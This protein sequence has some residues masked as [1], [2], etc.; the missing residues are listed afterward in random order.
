MKKLNRIKKLLLLSSTLFL[1]LVSFFKQTIVCAQL[2]CP[3][4]KSEISLINS[5]FEDKQ[6]VNARQYII[7]DQKNVPGWSTSARDSKIEIWG[8]G[9]SGVNAY[10]GNQFIELNSN[11]ISNLFQNFDANP[12]SS[13]SISFAHRGRET[14]DVIRV[15]IGEVGGP[16]TVLGTYT[17]GPSAWRHYTTQYTFPDNSSSHYVLMFSSA[18]SQKST[19]GNLLDAISVKPLFRKS[20]PNEGS[21]STSNKSS[22]SGGK[23]VGGTVVSAILIGIFKPNKKTSDSNLSKNERTDSFK[24][25]NNEGSIATDSGRI[26]EN[27]DRQFIQ[28]DSV[29]KRHHIDAV[30]QNINSPSNAEKTTLIPKK[31]LGNQIIRAI[32]GGT[33]IVIGA[34]VAARLILKP[35]NPSFIKTP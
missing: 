12:G 35:A 19:Y 32:K 13:I 31:R 7:T 17:T 14:N 5:D 28:T 24:F 33:I 21:Q 20:S 3:P 16:L 29:V 8:S 4:S 23:S 25:D 18:N 6:L 10:S 11:G 15:S 9:F 30:E 27:R 2:V 22:G 26:E 1:C 34:I